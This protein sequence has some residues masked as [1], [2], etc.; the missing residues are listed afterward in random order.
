MLGCEEA[1]CIEVLV[2][3]PSGCFGVGANYGSAVI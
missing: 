2:I 3:G 1:N